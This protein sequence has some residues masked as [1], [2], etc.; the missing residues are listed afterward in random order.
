MT[1]GE[2]A[3]NVLRQKK[4]VCSENF[5]FEK[6]FGL[7]M[8]GQAAEKINFTGATKRRKGNDHP[9]S[10]RTLEYRTKTNLWLQS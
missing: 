4:N 2:V 6:E 10:F 1:S 5:V 8:R 9:C 7:D 3:R